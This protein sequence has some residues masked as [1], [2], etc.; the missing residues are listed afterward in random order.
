MS[1]QEEGKANAQGNHAMSLEEK[2]KSG[3]SENFGRETKGGLGESMS[4][5]RKKKKENDLPD[6][7]P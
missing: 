2:E 4:E 1:R 6:P 3:R 7:L 5:D